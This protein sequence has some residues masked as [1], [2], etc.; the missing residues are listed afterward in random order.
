MLIFI[1]RKMEYIQIVS[2]TFNFIQHVKF[3]THKHGHT[4]DIVATIAGSVNASGFVAH[5]Y[6]ISLV[7]FTIEIIPEIKTYKVK[8]H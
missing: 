1:W 2:H 5:E 6:D 7:D 8:S 4:L 3:P